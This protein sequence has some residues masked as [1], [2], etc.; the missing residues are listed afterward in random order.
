MFE[1][2][3]ELGPDYGYQVEPVKSV[4]VVNLTDMIEAWKYLVI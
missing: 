3:Q 2:L 1:R 4:V